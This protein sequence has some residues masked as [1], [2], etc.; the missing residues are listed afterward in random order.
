MKREEKRG[1]RK[2]GAGKEGR[3][4]REGKK[5]EGIGPPTFLNLPPP[6]HINMSN[7]VSNERKVGRRITY[8]Y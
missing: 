5:R 4:R 8:G 2:V 6:M 7:L 3:E 1:E